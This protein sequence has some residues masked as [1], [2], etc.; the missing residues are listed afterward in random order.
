MATTEAPSR[1]HGTSCVFPLS[2]R[3]K[4]DNLLDRS[5][6]L[7]ERSEPLTNT[8]V[9]QADGPHDRPASETTTLLGL[10]EAIG[11]P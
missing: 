9:N 2:A 6:T 4:P 8:L 7:V 11:Q 5:H 3:L 10:D 1:V